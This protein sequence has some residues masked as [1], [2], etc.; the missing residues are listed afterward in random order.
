MLLGVMSVRAPHAVQGNGGSAP[1]HRRGLREGLDLPPVRPR[2]PSPPAVWPGATSAPAVMETALASPSTVPTP[3]PELGTGTSPRRTCP[4]PGPV[5]ADVPLPTPSC[6]LQPPASKS[7]FTNG[8]YVPSALAQVST[9]AL[10]G[11][12]HTLSFSPHPGASP[13]GP[14]PQAPMNPQGQPLQPLPL[15]RAPVR[16]PVMWSLGPHQGCGNHPAPWPP[17]KL[18]SG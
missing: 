10:D 5:S 2:P 6:L 9:L 17:P 14:R 1:R 16:L 18:W 7:R 4:L 15:R 12:S 8:P 13:L 3:G 11:P